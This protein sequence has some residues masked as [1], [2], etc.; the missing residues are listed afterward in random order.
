MFYQIFLSPQVKRW[1]LLLKNIRFTSYLT[2]CRKLKT[3]KTEIKLFPLYVIPH[4][5]Q[6][7]PQISCEPLQAATPIKGKTQS[8]SLCNPKK[9]RASRACVLS[10]KINQKNTSK[11]VTHWLELITEILSF[12]QIFSVCK[13]T[14]HLN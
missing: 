8:A 11:D 1:A 3:W 9:P 7:Q 2:N 4:K 12:L 14:I 13:T 10:L 5:N 6:S